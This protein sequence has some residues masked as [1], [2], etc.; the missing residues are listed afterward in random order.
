MQS[1]QGAPRSTAVCKAL[2][3]TA[4]SPLS[5]IQA[6]LLPCRTHASHLKLVLPPPCCLVVHLCSALL[7]LS[8]CS[9]LSS[10]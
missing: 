3:L 1:S 9:L 5:S 4:A 10:K 7:L 8:V 2:M 6:N